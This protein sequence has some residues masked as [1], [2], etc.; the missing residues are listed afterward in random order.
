MTVTNSQKYSA[1]RPT[2]FN[3]YLRT[4]MPWQFLRFLLINFRM[5]KMIIKSHGSKIPPNQELIRKPIEPLEK[6]SA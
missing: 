6:K 5:T 2:G 3:L 4:F 1:P